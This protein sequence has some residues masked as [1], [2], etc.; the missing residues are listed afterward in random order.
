MRGGTGTQYSQVWCLVRGRNTGSWTRK[1][2]RVQPETPLPWRPVNDVA[3]P[4]ICWS[5][6]ELPSSTLRVA[7]FSSQSW[8]NP[9]NTAFCW[10]EGNPSFWK[11]QFW[12]KLLRKL[13]KCNNS[14][15]K[16]NDWNDGWRIIEIRWHSFKKYS[17]F[18]RLC[19][20]QRLTGQKIFF[21]RFEHTRHKTQD[22]SRQGKTE[23]RAENFGLQRWCIF[24]S[25]SLSLGQ[26]WRKIRS[27]MS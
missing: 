11:F 3:L 10:S 19:H 26:F 4:A 15:R 22:N 17:Y 18:P 23:P 20:F 14:T 21:V 13:L 12:G 7:N 8:L 1:C 9:I 24:K 2:R 5:P 25:V 27:E 16:W 6:L